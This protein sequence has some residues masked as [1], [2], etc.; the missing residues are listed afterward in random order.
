RHADGSAS[1]TF[2]PRRFP[3]VQPIECRVVPSFTRLHETLIDDLALGQAA[4][5]QHDALGVSSEHKEGISSATC[6]FKRLSRHEP[7]LFQMPDIAV[8]PRVI[9]GVAE[10]RQIHGIDYAKPSD[11]YESCEFGLAKNVGAILEVVSARGTIGLQPGA[12][13]F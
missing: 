1:L 9:T 12:R 2:N 10:L 3:L 13:V 11:Y 5:Q 8:H 4:R 6:T 7:L